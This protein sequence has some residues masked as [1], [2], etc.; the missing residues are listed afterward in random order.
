MKLYNGQLVTRDSD[1]ILV[2]RDSGNVTPHL[3]LSP[4]T[5]SL[6]LGPG[7]R[8][9]CLTPIITRILAIKMRKIIPNSL[10]Y[11][12]FAKCNIRSCFGQ[13]YLVILIACN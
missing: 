8:L 11:T 7:T 1:R 10:I 4:P 3:L 9:L 6:I 12:Q 5:P 2:T 13:R